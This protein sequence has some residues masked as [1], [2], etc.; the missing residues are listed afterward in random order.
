MV[1]A[2][3]LIAAFA[4]ILSQLNPVPGRHV[5]DWPLESE[6]DR[7]WTRVELGFA[8]SLYGDRSVADPEPRI[9]LTPI[10]AD[11]IY[12]CGAYTGRVLG[13]ETEQYLVYIAR[14]MFQ[15]IDASEQ[16]TPLPVNVIIRDASDAD[17]REYCPN[18]PDSTR[19]TMLQ[20]A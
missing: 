9:L 15:N 17:L 10:F 8:E 13:Q 18:M 11:G 16:V 7:D 6:N 20:P 12:M 3:L 1:S 5:G 4:G 2:P 19:Q 14:F